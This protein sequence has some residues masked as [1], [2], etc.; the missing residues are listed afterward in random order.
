M[1]FLHS[2]SVLG[3]SGMGWRRG[4]DSNPRETFPPLRD[5]QSRLFGHSSTSPHSL[6]PVAMQVP[7]EY[8]SGLYHRIL[9]VNNEK[10]PRFP[11][12][13]RTWLGPVGDPRFPHSEVHQGGKDVEGNEGQQRQII[14]AVVPVSDPSGKLG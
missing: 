7:V 1:R 4:W 5:F 9:G 12:S 2:S 6:G 10:A 11:S 13:N 3:L 14:V 8:E